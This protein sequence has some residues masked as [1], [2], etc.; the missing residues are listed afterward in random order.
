MRFSSISLLVSL[1]SFASV[2]IATT[3][4]GFCI[5]DDGNGICQYDPDE[6][7]SLLAP[8]D[9]EFPCENTDEICT[10]NDDDPTGTAICS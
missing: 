9:A 4:D 1:A 3:F 2:A 10:F 6:G 8:C 5:V 7:I